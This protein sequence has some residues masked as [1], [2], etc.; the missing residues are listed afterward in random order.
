LQS[1]RVAINPTTVLKAY[2]V[3]EHE[4]LAAGRP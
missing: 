2:C 4:G 3:L 1:L